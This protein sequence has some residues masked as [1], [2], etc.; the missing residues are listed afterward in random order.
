MLTDFL[1]LTLFFYF[2]EN[3]LTTLFLEMIKKDAPIDILWKFLTGHSYQDMLANLFDSD[4]KWKQN[5]G[6]A[7]GDCP[8][9]TVFWIQLIWYPVYFLFTWCILHW[10]ISTS[11]HNIFLKIVINFIWYI[12]FHCIG[13]IW[14]RIK[15]INLQRKIKKQNASM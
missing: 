6:K 8:M 7:I 10:W 14:G 9:C 2:A 13:A 3:C 4:K 5:L 15:V 12:V 11:V 1:L